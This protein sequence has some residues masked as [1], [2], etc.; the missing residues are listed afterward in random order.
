MKM[1]KQHYQQFK[2]WL[3][4]K[5]EEKPDLFKKGYE[6]QGLTLTKY[7][8]DMIYGMNQCGWI[9]KTLY[10]YLIDYDIEVAAISII[11]EWIDE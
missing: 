2:E 9:Q 6:P 7:I 3:I 8:W 10:P 11:K 4:A 1:R 5:M